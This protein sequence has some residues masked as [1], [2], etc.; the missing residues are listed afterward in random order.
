MRK[1]KC[2]FCGEKLN[3]DDVFCKNCGN[4]IRNEDVV[5][6]AIIEDP[7]KNNTFIL[8]IIVML[9]IFIIGLGLYYLLFI[10]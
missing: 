1:R 6:D 4:E 5:K 10:K 8:S 9:L 2:E 3:K 7:N